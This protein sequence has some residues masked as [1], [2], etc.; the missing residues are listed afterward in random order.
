MPVTYTQK[1]QDFISTFCEDFKAEIAFMKDCKRSRSTRRQGLIEQSMGIALSIVSNA[2]EV[3]S[4]I[5]AVGGAVVN[6]VFSASEEA[7]L[8]NALGR[9]HFSGN[10]FLSQQIEQTARVAAVR[11]GNFIE[12]CTEKGVYTLAIC[13]VDRIMEYVTRKDKNGQRRSWECATFLEGLLQGESGRWV[14]ALTNTRIDTETKGSSPYTAEGMFARSGIAFRNEQGEWRYYAP[15]KKKQLFKKPNPEAVK[16]GFMILDQTTALAWSGFP[17]YTAV[18]FPTPTYST[19]PFAAD[20]NPL[21]AFASANTAIPTDPPGQDIINRELNEITTRFESTLERILSDLQQAKEASHD[22]REQLQHIQKTLRLLERK[23][24]IPPL[25][26]NIF[27]AF[28]ERQQNSAGQRACWIEPSTLSGE[29]L[30]QV[31]EQAT[32]ERTRC[33]FIVGESGSG[34]SVAVNQLAFAFWAKRKTL[35]DSIPEVISFNQV[36]PE[37]YASLLNDNTILLEH[38]FATQYGYTAEQIGQLQKEK[39]VLFFDEWDD[40]DS[41]LV[42]AIISKKILAHWPN[43]T[44]FFTIRTDKLVE[45]TKVFGDVITIAPWSA[46]T[47]ERYLQLRDQHDPEMTYANSVAT[48][49]DLRGLLF[50]NKES[51]ETDDA[52]DSVFLPEKLAFVGDILPAL[53]ATGKEGY[54]TSCDDLYTLLLEHYIQLTPCPTELLATQELFF[55]WVQKNSQQ[56]LCIPYPTVSDSFLGSFQALLSVMLELPLSS[57]PLVLRVEKQGQAYIIVSRSFAHYCKRRAHYEKEERRTLSTNRQTT[58]YVDALHD[59]F[60]SDT[61]EVTRDSSEKRPSQGGS[62]SLESPLKE[63]FK[64]TSTPVIIAHTL[65]P[66]EQAL[67]EKLT[68]ALQESIAGKKNRKLFYALIPNHID[69]PTNEKITHINEWVEKEHLLHDRREYLEHMIHYALEIAEEMGEY[70]KYD[71]FLGRPNIAKFSQIICDLDKSNRLQPFKTHRELSTLGSND[72]AITVVDRKISN[73]SDNLSADEVSAVEP[74]VTPSA[75]ASPP[76]NFQ[77]YATEEENWLQRIENQYRQYW[78]Q[79]KEC[80]GSTGQWQEVTTSSITKKWE[81]YLPQLKAEMQRFKNKKIAI[82]KKVVAALTYLVANKGKIADAEKFNYLKAFNTFFETEIQAIERAKNEHRKHLLDSFGLSY[83]FFHNERNKL[84]GD[85][86]DSIPTEDSPLLHTIEQGTPLVSVIPYAWERFECLVNTTP[87]L[88]LAYHHSCSEVE[89]NKFKES[90]HN[91]HYGSALDWIIKQ[92][93][94]KNYTANHVAF[95]LKKFMREWAAKDKGLNSFWQNCSF[96][97]QQHIISHLANNKKEDADLGRIAP[98]LF[99]EA[100][101]VVK[102]AQLT[103]FEWIAAARTTFYRPHTGSEIKQLESWRTLIIREG[104]ITLVSDELNRHYPKPKIGFLENF[105]C[106]GLHPDVSTNKTA[107]LF[108]LLKVAVE[109]RQ[110]SQALERLKRMIVHCLNCGASTRVINAQHQSVLTYAAE[111]SDQYPLP[112]FKEITGLLMNVRFHFEDNEGERKLATCLKEMKHH[113][114]HYQ[115][116]F[117]D[118]EKSILG[119]ILRNEA[120]RKDRKESLERYCDCLYKLRYDRVNIVDHL[121]EMNEM[122]VNGKRREGI[123]YSGSSELH[124]KMLTL[125]KKHSDAFKVHRK[126]ELVK[127]KRV[128]AVVPWKNDP[129]TAYYDGLQGGVGAIVNQ[130]SDKDARI[131]RLEE[132]N[133]ALQGQNAAQANI[134]RELQRKLL[135]QEES[136]NKQIEDLKGMINHVREQKESSQEATSFTRSRK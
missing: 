99:S 26:D 124:D 83:A 25:L 80:L 22:I 8:E 58:V 1:Q 44:I 23:T 116:I 88:Q 131:R 56:T 53:M 60:F 69:P 89:K 126:L 11:Y 20:F 92:F 128:E 66:S 49:K 133:A 29:N 5:S 77:Q 78:Q 9:E 48:N 4:A 75:I 46:N 15:P 17:Q 94:L 125:I 55:A 67:L 79:Q 32:E 61:P 90:I 127:G 112:F 113:L 63:S 129:R 41:S 105:I 97:R 18:T 43:S 51:S 59:A 111:L 50:E 64:E 38:Y 36:T 35:T 16:Y 76:Q 34:K 117:S 57:T 130:L 7:R 84:E 37:R 19:P 62:L 71:S 120:L 134:I 24:F 102:K 65:F 87:F 21:Q 101:E 118:S 85:Q 12:E 2:G 52:S 86:N 114:D 93:S 72:N 40:A 81:A 68:Q 109:K 13:G 136:F 33:H 3:G 31:V 103:A 95:E 119:A 115:K 98:T 45:S 104:Q 30:F 42:Q 96:E 82:G 108:Y 110:S 73:N 91:G 28:Q 54:P 132:E 135:E 6:A 70:N 10:A 47:M 100:M 27:D 106:L 123:F 14:Q 107:L 121:N 39:W 122:A 74:P